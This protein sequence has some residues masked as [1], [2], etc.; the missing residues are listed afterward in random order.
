MLTKFYFDAK[1]NL[2]YINVEYGKR[3]FS[4]DEF[5]GVDIIDYWICIHFKGRGFIRITKSMSTEDYERALESLQIALQEAN[6]YKQKKEH[7]GFQKQFTLA[8]ARAGYW[9]GNEKIDN[10]IKGKL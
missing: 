7:E 10:L 8:N 6:E 4:P 5:V 2:I 1:S 9:S 3:M